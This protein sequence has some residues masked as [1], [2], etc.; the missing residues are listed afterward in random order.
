[1]GEEGEGGG[2]GRGGV[3]FSS[4]AT[5]QSEV[6]VEKPGNGKTVPGGFRSSCGSQNSPLAATGPRLRPDVRVFGSVNVEPCRTTTLS[7]GREFPSE[8]IFRMP[9]QIRRPHSVK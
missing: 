2:G 5:V 9:M 3:C 6:D 8:N 7:A 1:M 4:G